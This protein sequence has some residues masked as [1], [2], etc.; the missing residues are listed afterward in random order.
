MLGTGISRAQALD[1]TGEFR[2]TIDRYRGSRNAYLNFGAANAIQ[3]IYV[4]PTNSLRT[5]VIAIL[6]HSSDAAAQRFDI[7]DGGAVKNFPTIEIPLTANVILDIEDLGGGLVIATDLRV[8][9]TANE[10]E[11]WCC[12]LTEWDDASHAE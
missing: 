2:S 1:Q 8:D 12:Y 3:T 6:A 5:R 9:P 11:F 10:L 7:S 4:N